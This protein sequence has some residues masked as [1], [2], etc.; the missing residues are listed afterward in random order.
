MPNFVANFTWER[1]TKNTER[2][3]EDPVDGQPPR[4]GTLYI[5]R[6]AIGK[7]KRVKVTVEVIE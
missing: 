6:F 3:Q 1:S 7:A 2:F 4:I 5:Q